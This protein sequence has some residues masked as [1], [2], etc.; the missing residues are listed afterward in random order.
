[1]NGGKN[2]WCGVSPHFHVPKRTKISMRGSASSASQW[3]KNFFFSI[4]AAL[5][6]SAKTRPRAHWSLFTGEIRE[7]EVIGIGFTFRQKMTHF[8]ERNSFLQSIFQYWVTHGLTGPTG[9]CDYSTTSFLSRLLSLDGTNPGRSREQMCETVDCS[10][11]HRTRAVICFLEQP[12][13]IT[14]P[15]WLDFYSVSLRQRQLWECVLSTTYFFFP[16]LPTA[17]LSNADK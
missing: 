4:G 8:D 16:H 3:R 9:S 10:P 6:K 17:T 12:R 1:M 2:T 14:P 5:R 13:P 11:S 7:S 15:N